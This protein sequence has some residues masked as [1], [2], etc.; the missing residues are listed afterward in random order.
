MPSQGTGSQAAGRRWTVPGV[1]A[2][3][4]FK[5]MLRT[6]IKRRSALKCRGCA[7]DRG[8]PVSL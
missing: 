5:W 8:L 1:K 6:Q 3:A 7:P 4:A 2:A